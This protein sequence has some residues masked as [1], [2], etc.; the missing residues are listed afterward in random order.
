MLHPS[1][2]YVMAKYTHAIW[3]RHNRTPPN[4]IA[5]LI[6]ALPEARG[7]E[8]DDPPSPYVRLARERTRQ[9]DAERDF[10]TNPE[11]PAIRFYIET[12]PR[13]EEGRGLVTLIPLTWIN[14]LL[15]SG[16]FSPTKLGRQLGFRKRH[17]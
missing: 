4:E 3:S 15:S 11:N 14:S 17:G 2:Y 1:S 7:Y 12:N 6:S 16:R 10:W 9:G 8:F 13:Y 5:D